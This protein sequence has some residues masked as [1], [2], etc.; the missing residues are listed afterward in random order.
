MK[1]ITQNDLEQVADQMLA[2][3]FGEVDV[4]MVTQGI[5]DTT[6]K[7]IIRENLYRDMEYFYRYGDVFFTDDEM[8]GIV[9]LIDG[10]K[11]SSF[12]KTILSLKSNKIITNAATKEELKLLNSNAKKVQEVHSFNW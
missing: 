12:K 1:K 3:F 6:A 10:K 2:I 9:A 7:T 11:F 5:N 8:S 4:S